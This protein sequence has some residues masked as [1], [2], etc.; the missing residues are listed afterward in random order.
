MSRA[1]VHDKVY[2]VKQVESRSEKKRLPAMRHAFTSVYSE[3]QM[4]IILRHK[5]AGSKCTTLDIFTLRAC[6]VRFLFRNLQQ[7]QRLA[8]FGVLML[9]AS[10]PKKNCM[11]SDERLAFLDVDAFATSKLK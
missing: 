7:T 9:K 2:Y 11:E 6:L 8:S 10:I 1:L 3:K 5:M 4:P